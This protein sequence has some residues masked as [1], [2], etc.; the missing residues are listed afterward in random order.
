MRALDRVT[1]GD[2]LG[3]PSDSDMLFSCSDRGKDAGSRSS[4]GSCGIAAVTSP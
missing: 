3:G 1:A 4:G 2:A